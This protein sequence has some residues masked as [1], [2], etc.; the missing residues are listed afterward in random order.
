MVHEVFLP[1]ELLGAIYDYD[2]TLFRKLFVG[3][4]DAPVMLLEL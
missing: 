4:E 1:H 2:A 3:T